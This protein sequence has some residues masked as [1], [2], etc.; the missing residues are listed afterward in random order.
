MPSTTHS[1]QTRLDAVTADHARREAD[2]CGISLE[3]WV[4][5]VLRRELR[6]AGQADALAPQTC[7]AV[8]ANLHLLHA[9]ML[10]RMG[11]EAT[12]RAVERA[13]QAAR[14]AIAAELARAAEVEP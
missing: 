13:V 12:A 6:H 1:F 7:E 4:E 2:R 8:V 14:K 10:D 11:P 5:S 3:E 9:L